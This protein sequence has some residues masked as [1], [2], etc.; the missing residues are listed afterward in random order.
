MK[1]REPAASLWVG[2]VVGLPLLVAFFLVGAFAAH[3]MK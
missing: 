2:A 1:D 3:W